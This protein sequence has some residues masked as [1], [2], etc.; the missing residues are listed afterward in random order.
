MTPSRCLPGTAVKLGLKLHPFPPAPL[1]PGQTSRLRA[2]LTPAP[3]NHSER[4][5]TIST[6]EMFAM[7]EV[8]SMI[9][10]AVS[11]I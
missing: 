4:L 10:L 11:V 9:V 3:W 6:P 8:Q 2:Q 7:K 1:K 5:S